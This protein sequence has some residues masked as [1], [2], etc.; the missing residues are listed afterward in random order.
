MSSR[1]LDSGEWGCALLSNIVIVGA[2]G[3]LDVT[4]ITEGSNLFG[5]ILPV[6][7]GLI[8]VKDVRSSPSGAVPS[9]KCIVAPAFRASST[10]TCPTGPVS[11]I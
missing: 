8:G 9:N 5:N 11:S 7:F 1:L 10:I 3:M 4:G 2:T 6:N